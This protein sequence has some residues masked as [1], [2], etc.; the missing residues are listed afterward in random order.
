MTEIEPYVPRQPAPAV[1]RPDIDSWIAVVGDVAK[2]ASHISDTAFVPD[3]LRGN[4]AAVAAAILSGREAGVGPMAS[5][6]NINI[7][8]GKP[9][10]SALLMRQLA[11]AAGHHIR[12]VE[13]T[14]SRCVVEGRRRDEGTWERVVFTA[15][16]ARRARI[17]LGGYPEDKLVARATA[18]LC[19]RLFADAIGGTPYTV[20]ELEDGVDDEVIDLT[21]PAPTAVEPPRR[22]AQRRTTPK[23]RP[24]AAAHSIAPPPPADP[25]PDEN[26]PPLPGEPGFD[27]NVEVTVIPHLPPITDPQMRKMQ[28]VFT[29]HGIRARGDRLLT[30]SQLAGRDLDSAK[31]LTAAEA[32]VVI[33]TLERIAAVA[34]E[35]FGDFLAR[36]IEATGASVDHDPDTGEVLDQ[37]ALDEEP[38]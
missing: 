28:T 26:L 14:D 32:S 13:T 12:Y 37:P 2:L 21:A 7:I 16:Q 10:Q 1:L 24:A 34:G 6:Q 5:L 27:G 33:D 29:K 19:R 17:D 20:E 23:T 18:R 11:L 3:A 8:K 35:E 9:G 25:T 30:A 31:D 22:T 4:A 38:T 15:D 36:L